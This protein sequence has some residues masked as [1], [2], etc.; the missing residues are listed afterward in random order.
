MLAEAILELV[1]GLKAVGAADVAGALDRCGHHGNPL[2]SRGVR[3]LHP[4]PPAGYVAPARSRPRSMDP[5]PLAV[6]GLPVA[7]GVE[8]GSWAEG[9]KTF[10][11]LKA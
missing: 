2:V 7:L 10:Q 9:L 6:S 5:T 3:P 11:G 8:L 4:R 1:R